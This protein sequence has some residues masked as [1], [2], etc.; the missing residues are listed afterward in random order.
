[1][2]ATFPVERVLRERTCDM[3]F[4]A[5]VGNAWIC[6]ATQQLAQR[7]LTRRL[8]AVMRNLTTG[9]LTTHFDLPVSLRILPRAIELCLLHA[10]LPV[11]TTHIIVPRITFT[12]GHY[13]TTGKPHLLEMQ[14]STPT[15]LN[16]LRAG[17]LDQI[18]AGAHVT[19]R[20]VYLTSPGHL[21]DDPFP[22]V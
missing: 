16:R 7:P 14:M 11:G 4:P 15:A 3:I 10:C 6:D 8:G 1:M 21:R 5:A 2:I 22:A 9:H 19:P 13:V 17:H 18:V 20:P 12:N